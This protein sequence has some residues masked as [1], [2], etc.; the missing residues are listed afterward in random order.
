[1]GVAVTLNAEEILLDVAV[2]VRH[3]RERAELAMAARREREQLGLAFI[4]LPTTKESS[5]CH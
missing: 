2:I 4:D 5:E 3:A 1:M